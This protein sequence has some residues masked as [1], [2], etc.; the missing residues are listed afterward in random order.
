L[1]VLATVGFRV[2]PYNPDQRP[3][4]VVGIVPPVDVAVVGFD[5]D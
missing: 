2:E 3:V 5:V 1:Q 4:V